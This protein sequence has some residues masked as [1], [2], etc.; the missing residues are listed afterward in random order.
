LDAQTLEI[1]EVSVRGEFR[2]L[3]TPFRPTFPKKMLGERLLVACAARISVI[4]A[5]QHSRKRINELKRI[6]SF[7]G[8]KPPQKCGTPKT[9][10]G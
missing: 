5:Q 7:C 10:M 6:K 4:R 1:F 3:S 2:P 9:G 8:A